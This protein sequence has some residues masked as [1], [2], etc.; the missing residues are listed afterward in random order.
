[1]YSSKE[2]HGKDRFVWEFAGKSVEATAAKIPD[3]RDPQ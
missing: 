1:M 3:K 2:R